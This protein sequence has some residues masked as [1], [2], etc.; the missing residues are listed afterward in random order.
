MAAGDRNKNGKPK[1]LVKHYGE[2]LNDNHYLLA[3]CGNK[4]AGYVSYDKNE[5]TCIKC[6]NKI[7]TWKLIDLL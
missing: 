7:K 4:R 1:D 3:I 5:I 6:I 2:V